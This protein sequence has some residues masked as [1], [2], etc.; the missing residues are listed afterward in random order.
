MARIQLVSSAANPLV[1]DVRRAI[2]RGGLTDDGSCVAES[3][4]LL[5]EALRSQRDVPIVLV[6]RIH[7]IRSRAPCVW[8]PGHTHRRI[9]RRALSN[10]RHYR[11]EPG[12]HRARA[13]ACLVDRATVPRPESRHR[14][15]RP[16]GPRQCG[17]H[18]TRRGSVR[19]HRRHV[20]QRQCQ[21]V[22]SEDAAGIRRFAVS[23]PVSRRRRRA[24]QHA[25]H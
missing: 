19:R 13:P 11:N 3:F 9:A 23:R 7:S 10:R 16:A 12:R 20:H 21:P 18:R 17:R 8:T 5:E 2:T 6:S 1:K 14:A 25:P 15:R 24:A 4:H 22:S